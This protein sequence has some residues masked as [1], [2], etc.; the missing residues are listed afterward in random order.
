MSFTEK[1]DKL[2]KE[3]NINKAELSRAS[4]I[5]YTTIDG[6][7]K[8]GSDNVKLSTLK[9]L[10]SFFH[11]S[12]DYLVDD[13]VSSDVQTTV[14]VH[15]DGNEYTEEE[16]DKIKEFAAFVKSSRKTDEKGEHLA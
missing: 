10:C 1:L 5:P 13:S 9:R 6:F 16:L 4:G 3:K 2:M 12:L 8:K 15:F 7:Y 11:C 14:A